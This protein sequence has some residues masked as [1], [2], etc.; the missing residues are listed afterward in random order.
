MLSV[1]STRPCRRR[2]VQ[3]EVA[4]GVPG[5]R[6]RPGRRRGCRAC[7]A[8][9][10]AAGCAPPTRRRWCAAIPVG[11]AVT[12]PLS[13]NSRSAR[14]K[15]WT[16]VSGYACIRPCMGLLPRFRE[17]IVQSRDRH[18]HTRPARTTSS[19]SPTRRSTASS[20]AITVAAR[21]R[22]LIVAL[23]GVGRPAVLERPDRV[24]DHVRRDRAR[25]H[26][27][28]PPAVH[29]PRLQGRPRRARDV[30]DPR[31]GGDR[32]PGHLLGRRPP[33]APRVLRPARR[34]AQPARRPRPR[35]RGRAARA[36]ARPRRLAVHPHAAR[37][38]RALRAGP[39][40]RPDRP[41]RS[42]ARSSSGR[43]AACVVPSCSAG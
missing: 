29:P 27:R 7:R 6:A 15:E 35:P 33:Q 5:E 3:L 2:E 10:R 11:V 1:C 37:P 39:A 20:P 17:L 18:R 12:I 34:P 4:R 26:R 42:T 13:G 38:P 14:S 25:R 24:R 43:S 32:G 8:R 9:R 22:L 21:R 23:A 41:L 28:L 19:P 30:R 31:L 36:A 40:R 16:S